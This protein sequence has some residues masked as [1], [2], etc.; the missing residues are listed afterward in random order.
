VTGP[1]LDIN[2]AADYLDLSSRSIRRRLDKIPHFR[3]DFGL[4]FAPEDLSAYMQSFR[5]EPTL[6]AKV[7][8]GDILGPRKRRAG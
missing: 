6:P 5:Q 8:L 2:G 1:Y 7:D 4:R 3:C